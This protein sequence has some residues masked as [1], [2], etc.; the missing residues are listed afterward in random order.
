M[1]S[2]IILAAGSSTR[3]GQ[4]KQYVRLGNET[5]LERAVRI[6][7]FADLSPVF[8]VV[9]SAVAKNPSS[10]TGVE[11]I[12][13]PSDVR[14]EVLIND[15]AAEGMA[16]SIRLGVRAA[17]EAAAVGAVVLACDQ[18][19][20]TP[21]HLRTLIQAETEVRASSYAGRTGIPAY[22]PN[23]LFEQL[24]QLAGDMGARDLL[25]HAAA[26][27]LIHGELDIDTPADLA[28]ARD[29][30]ADLASQ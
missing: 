26:V 8:V 19:A 30:Y 13:R 25:R 21:E 16:S 10:V 2:A 27:P 15:E 22:F 17:I 9:S 1:P 20:V 3:L 28:R 18:V 11:G 12:N 29:V 6:A 14:V 4:P 24:L 23:S 5:L 7:V